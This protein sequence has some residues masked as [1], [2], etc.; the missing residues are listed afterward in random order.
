MVLPVVS[1]ITEQ[2]WTNIILGK[3][4][5]QS[6]GRGLRKPPSQTR[7]PSHSLTLRSYFGKVGMRHFHLQRN[8]EWKPTINLDKVRENS[9]QLDS[10]SVL[11]DIRNSFGHW[12]PRRPVKLTFPARR[13][14]PLPFSTSYHSDSP[15]CLAKVDSQ[16]SQSLSVHDGSARKQNAR[17]RRPVVLLSWSHKRCLKSE[18]NFYSC[19]SGRIMREGSS[20]EIHEQFKNANDEAMLAGSHK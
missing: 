7:H 16:R 15:K 5:P 8:H 1:I 20:R 9:H 3:Q 14:I 2:T 6:P 13:L 11:T 17:S 10:L 19:A 12:Y 18:F 4:S